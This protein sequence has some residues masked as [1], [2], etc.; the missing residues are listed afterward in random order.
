M[1]ILL[2]LLAVAAVAWVAAVF[3]RDIVAANLPAPKPAAVPRK[4]TVAK[5][6]VGRPRKTVDPRAG[7]VWIENG[8][9]SGWVVKK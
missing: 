4:K 5:R 9:R 2:P 8:N 1:I 3:V 7:Q 6:P